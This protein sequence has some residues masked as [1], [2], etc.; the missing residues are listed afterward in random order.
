MYDNLIYLANVILG[1]IGFSIALN[2]C[3]K[4]MLQKPL[5]CPLNMKCEQVIYSK[6]AKFLG[7]PVDFLGMFYYGIIVISYSTFLFLPATRTPSSILTISIITISGFLFSIY[8]TSVQIFKLK[9]W[10]SWCLTS[11]AIST[12]MAILISQ[13]SYL[14]KNIT[15]LA[16]G[17]RDIFIVGHSL[18][19]SFGFSVAIIGELLFIHFLKDNR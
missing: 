18:A 17:Y 13:T 3:C 9:E 16:E 8:L 14:A 1:I 12:A 2:I 5:V 19:I 7:I 4:K 6:Y 10:C 15:Y 11:A